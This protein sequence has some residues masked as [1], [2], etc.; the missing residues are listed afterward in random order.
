MKKTLKITGVSLV[1]IVVLLIIVNLF[2]SRSIRTEIVIDAPADVVWN[3]LLDHQS[4]PQWNPFI[5]T[6]SGSTTP[7]D[8]LAVTVQSEGNDPMNFTPVVL[9]NN[10]NKEFRWVGKLLVRGIFDGEHYFILEKV[11]SNQTKFIHGEN[12]TGILSGIFMGMI[13]EDTEGGFKS[14]NQA[15]KKRSENN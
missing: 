15:L 3:I 12:F 10:T 9:V 11:N 8:N 13:R 2:T 4:Y 1:V 6:I 7:G 5:K 14:M